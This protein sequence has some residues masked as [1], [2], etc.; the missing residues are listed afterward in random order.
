MY[1]VG[2]TICWK[3]TIGNNGTDND[4]NV[5]FTDLL[6]TGLTFVSIEQETAPG[7]WVDV[8]SN[9]NVITG[10]YTVGNFLTTDVFIYRICA[11][12]TQSGTYTNSASITGD[13]NDTV[14]TNNNDTDD[15]LVELKSDLS[16][17]KIISPSPESRISSSDI[18]PVTGTSQI[19]V[20]N[21]DCDGT[22]NVLCG[23]PAR[24]VVQIRDAG[25]TG[26][27]TD[28]EEI[29]GNTGDAVSTYTS[30]LSGTSSILNHIPDTDIIF[31][32]AGGTVFQLDKQGWANATGNVFDAYT[33]GHNDTNDLAGY[34]KAKEFRFI[35][36]V[37]GNGSTSCPTESI[38]TDNTDVL[39][40]KFSLFRMIGKAWQANNIGL[41]GNDSAFH[42]Q[43]WSYDVSIHNDVINGISNEVNIDLNMPP[44]GT[45]T[46]STRLN[47]WYNYPDLV[48]NAV[49]Q[50]DGSSSN[51]LGMIT[52]FENSGI[53]TSTRSINDYAIWDQALSGNRDC[54]L[55]FVQNTRLYNQP[56]SSVT[57]WEQS[58]DGVTWNTLTQTGGTTTNMDSSYPIVFTSPQQ[59]ITSTVRAIVGGESINRSSE[60]MTNFIY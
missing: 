55:S 39:E 54:N 26:V 6:P 2:N 12:A 7:V 16:I 49:I 32:C 53:A 27:W 52:T 50:V 46:V 11:I 31:D 14:T 19:T 28:Y 13:N 47:E 3:I 43:G 4:T 44:C 20:T 9:Y 29:T 48:E 23:V 58:T 24:L 45:T 34:T 8:S 60:Y 40:A 33:T 35:T 1:V 17:T 15:I 21:T 41:C 22:S 30:T 37:G 56:A 42:I 38:N 36:Y 59:L 25:S 57:Q 10:V 18:D 51:G 5:T